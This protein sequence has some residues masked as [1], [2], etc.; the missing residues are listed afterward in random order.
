MFANEIDINEFLDTK[1]KRTMVESITEFKEFKEDT[2][3]S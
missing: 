2:F 1:F 3:F